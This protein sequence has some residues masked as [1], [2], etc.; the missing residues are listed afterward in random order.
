M[1]T[2]RLKKSNFC[3]GV[4]VH[5]VEEE[6]LAGLP[7]ELLFLCFFLGLSLLLGLVVYLAQGIRVGDAGRCSQLGRGCLVFDEITRWQVLMVLPNWEAFLPY[8]GSEASG[9]WQ[10]R[11]HR[12]CG[13]GSRFGGTIGTCHIPVPLCFIGKQIQN[14]KPE[15]L[16]GN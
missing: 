7:G 2:S 12:P 5:L 1:F 10:G 4:F 15:P 3:L 13:D 8:A 16:Y 9:V 11:I 14:R 6:L